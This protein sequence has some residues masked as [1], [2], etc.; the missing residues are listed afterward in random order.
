MK[1]QHLQTVFEFP[2]VASVDRPTQPQEPNEFWTQDT[3]N[4]LFSII[5]VNEWQIIISTQ[6]DIDL[7]GTTE[8]A[9]SYQ[10]CIIISQARLPQV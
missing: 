7:Y 10:G 2:F 8:C 6:S 1:F 4:S 9:P 3:L 5:L